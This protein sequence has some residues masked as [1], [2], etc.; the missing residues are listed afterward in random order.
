MEKMLD[1]KSR[2]FAK[3]MRDTMIYDKSKNEVQIGTNLNVNGQIKSSILEVNE[4]YTTTM[5]LYGGFVAEEECSA[6]SFLQN[7]TFSSIPAFLDINSLPTTSGE[8][9]FMAKLQ[10]E[11]TF[12]NFKNVS[13]P[14][15]ID[16]GNA[17]ILIDP[18]ID[19]TNTFTSMSSIPGANNNF[20]TFKANLGNIKF[21]IIILHGAVYI[22]SQYQF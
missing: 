7:P 21:V 5:E 10:N 19:I 22:T 13:V 3:N 14:L 8:K 4:L 1:K 11:V 6:P 18:R 12:L 15:K 9:V 2:D 20:A 16:V 17:L